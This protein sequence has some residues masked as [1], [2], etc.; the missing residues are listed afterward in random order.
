MIAV[1][2]ISLYIPPIEQEFGWSRVQV[3]FAFT[4]VAYM[5]VL[6]SPL[7]GFLVDRF[8]PRRVV[9]TSIPL[10][11][12]SLAALY[13]TAGEPARVLRALGARAG[14]GLGLWPLGYLQ[15][16]TPWF[17]RKLGLVA[18]L[19]ERGNRPRQHAAADARDRPDDR[20][21][22]L[23][24]RAA[25]ARR[26]GPVRELADRRL[27]RLREPSPATPRR[28][29]S[30]PRRRRSACPFRKRCASRRS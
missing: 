10:F 17:D 11:A 20:R 22:Q 25:R 13:F 28:S 14:L 23:A 7:Q 16:V 19:R 21:L 26:V 9:L 6:M 29:S 3:S 15:A 18:R 27:L 24:A 5:I 30:A 12:A 8:G 2:T 1:L 4:I